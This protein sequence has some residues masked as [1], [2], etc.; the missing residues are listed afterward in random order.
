MEGSTESEV[1]SGDRRVLIVDD[2]PDFCD[3]VRNYLQ[4]RGALDVE[5]A[6]SGFAAGLTIARFKPAV[7][8]MDILMPDMD[9]F[10][11]LKMMRSDPEMQEIPVIACT[12]YRDPQI[13]DRVRRESFH[14]YIEK[15][16][17]LDRLLEMIEQAMRGQRPKG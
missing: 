10:E 13:E 8:V 4:V 17:K 5:V 16:L 2:E 11:V 6:L 15:P 14:G 9:G 7:V 12:A 1:P 3:L